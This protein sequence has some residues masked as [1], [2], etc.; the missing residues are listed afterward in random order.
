M[1]YVDTPGIVG[2]K[3]EDRRYQAEAA[4]MA[5]R[6]STLVILPTAMGKTSIALRVA[7]PVLTKGRKVLMMAPTKPL[8][9]QHQVFFS[10]MIDGHSVVLLNGNMSPDK[11]A[12]ALSRG[13]FVISTPQC[14]ANDLESGR[15]GLEDFGLVIYDEAHKATGGYAY[16]DVARF[17]PGDALSLGMTASPGSDVAKVEEICNNLSINNIFVRTEDDPDVSPYIHDTFVNRIV[18]KMPEDLLNISGILR[19]MLDFYFTNL[20]NMGLLINPGWPV[21]TKHLL[22]IGQSL[23]SRLANGERNVVIYRG[24]KFQSMCI[25][26]LRAIDYAET[27]GMTVLRSY[28]AKIEADA[29][30][31]A[32]KADA[33]I[34]ANP[35]YKKARDITLVSR[36][37]HPKVSR[38]MSLVSRLVGEGGRMIVFTQYRETCDVLCD[39]L[40]KVDGARVCKLIGHSNG[41]QAQK[42][43]VGNL[44]DFRNGKY[45]VVISTSVG[46]EGLDIASTN[47]VIF[48]EPVPSAIRTIQRRGRTGRKNDGDVYVLVAAGTVDEVTEASA[49]R[50]EE[51]MREGLESLGKRLSKRSGPC[52][53][54]TFIT[55]F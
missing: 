40:S 9:D 11:R 29:L 55:S 24:L 18:V 2:R 6:D 44:D 27:Q 21:S 42:E 25:K 53:G 54:Q 4:S 30:S 34:V 39:K 32:S 20:R 36:V 47:A 51:Q 28:L 14:I 5:L 48:Y 17:V 41:G 35:L 13:E 31:G 16:V 15:Y 22:A 3:L 10:E 23:Q 43:Q 12:A 1:E 37:E 8:V 7:A 50:K 49:K 38:I 46:E 45:N 26:L 33:E 52:R 19:E